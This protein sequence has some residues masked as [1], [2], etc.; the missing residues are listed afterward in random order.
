MSLLDG[1]VALV[2][3]ASKCVGAGIAKGL[4]AAGTCVVANYA[5]S[6]EGAGRAIV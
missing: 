5:S 3:R 1:M 4:A 2:K 6:K